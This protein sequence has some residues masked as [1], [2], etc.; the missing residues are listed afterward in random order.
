[1]VGFAQCAKVKAR[2]NKET[3]KDS[4]SGENLK[5]GGPSARTRTFSIIFNEV[6]YIEGKMSLCFTT[7]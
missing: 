5:F 7:V 4:T 6:E 3:D 1:V 2:S